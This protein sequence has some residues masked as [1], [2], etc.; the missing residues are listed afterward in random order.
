MKTERFL[1]GADPIRRQLLGAQP[2]GIGGCF[3]AQEAD[4]ALRGWIAREI[5]PEAVAS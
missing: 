4:V 5:G 3:D 1:A 2:N